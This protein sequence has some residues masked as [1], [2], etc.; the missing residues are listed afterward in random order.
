MLLSYSH[1][2]KDDL[3]IEHNTQY[4]LK[5]VP[6]AVFFARLLTHKK[7]TNTQRIARRAKNAR[8]LA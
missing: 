5:D 3:S 6:T 2:A 7:N 1:F 4:K 8:F